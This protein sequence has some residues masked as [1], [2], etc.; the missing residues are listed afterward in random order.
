M[1]SD[2]LFEKLYL[3]KDALSDSAQTIIENNIE[4]YNSADPGKLYWYKYRIK[5]GGDEAAVKAL[6]KD[7][8][9]ALEL[10]FKHMEFSIK[11]GSRVYMKM[12][13]GRIVGMRE[14]IEEIMEGLREKSKNGDSPT[15]EELDQA[16]DRIDEI[17]ARTDA[18]T[19]EIDRTLTAADLKV[20]YVCGATGG[21]KLLEALA[22]PVKREQRHRAADY[23]DPSTV[24]SNAQLFFKDYPKNTIHRDVVE[25]YDHIKELVG[26]SPL[27]D[28]LKTDPTNALLAVSAT[29]QPRA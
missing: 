19:A 2:T 17:N 6:A 3:N 14:E 5:D 10:G 21:A 18:M 29:P 11:E 27:P 1:V 15:T 26:E 22:D 7:E 8:N 4:R 23:T 9:I 12:L 13:S 24:E 28:S 20:F 16:T 25:F